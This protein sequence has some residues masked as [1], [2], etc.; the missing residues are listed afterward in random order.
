MNSKGDLVYLAHR[1]PYPP[2]K[3]EKIRAYHVLKHLAENY[4]IHLGC[5]AD[6]PEDQ[7]YAAPLKEICASVLVAPLNRKAA[8][9]RGLAHLMAGG[10]LSEGYFHDTR[11][12]RFVADTVERTKPQAMFVYCSAMAPYAMP[13]AKSHRVLLDMVDVDSEKYRAYSRNAAWPLSMLYAKE[14]RAL[15]ALERRSALAFDRS[16]FVSKAEADTFLKNA[17]EAAERVGYFHNGVDLDY[18][19][20]AQDFVS[21]FATD[22]LPVVFTGTMD[23]RPNIEAVTWFADMVLPEVR[24]HHANAEFWIVG[25]NPAQS[26]SKLANVGG[27]HVTGRVPDVRPYLRHARCVVAPLHIARGVQ[28]KVLEAMAMGKAVVATQAAC[29][30]I[31]AEAG[32]ELVLAEGPEA[33]AAAVCSLLSGDAGH[34]AQAARARVEADYRWTGNLQTLDRFLTDTVHRDGSRGAMWTPQTTGRVLGIA[35]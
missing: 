27:I 13:Y 18:F 12:A 23:Y 2:D 34:I 29:E 6:Y 35:S 11:M 15:F 28:N 21:P 1:V 22:T 31:S 30:G 7:K 25:A 14:A 26:V 24:R 3:G 4:R 33:F 9:A 8:L 32:T 17:P 5:F 19:S 16:F 20:P 10:C